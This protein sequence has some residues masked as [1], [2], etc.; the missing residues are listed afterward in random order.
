MRRYKLSS[1]WVDFDRESDANWVDFSSEM[2][3]YCPD[4][5]KARIYAVD[6]YRNAE[7]NL[8]MQRH[9]LYCAGKIPSYLE[10]LYR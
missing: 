6:I 8:D 1:Y 2:S 7:R 3:K 5:I 9:F 4:F 10:A